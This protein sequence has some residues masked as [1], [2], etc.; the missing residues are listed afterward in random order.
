MRWFYIYDEFE[1]CVFSLMILCEHLGLMCNNRREM[2][3][4]KV[5]TRSPKCLLF[6]IFLE[7]CL[8]FPDDLI[9]SCFFS[10]C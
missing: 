4:E 2:S 1:M 5:Y 8:N 9:W 6:I 3:G 10:N 7:R